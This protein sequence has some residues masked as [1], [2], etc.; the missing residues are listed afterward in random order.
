MHSQNRGAFFFNMYGTEVIK[1]LEEWVPPGVAWKDD[2][3]GLQVGSEDVK[4]KNILVALDLNQKVVDQAIQKNCNFIFTHHPFIFSPIKKLDFQNDPK[5]VIIKELVKNDITLYSAHTNLDFTIGGVSFEL[6]KKLQLRDIKFLLNEKNNQYKL[7]VFVPIEDVEVVSEAIFNAGGGVIG[8]YKKCS[9]QLVGEGT[10]EGSGSSN[11]QK[12]KKQ[13]FET[14]VE[15][16]LEVLVNSWELKS[17]ISA[18]LSVHPYEE[19]AYDVYVLNNKN[20]NYGY[21]AIGKLEKSLKIN[22]FLSH[23]KSMLGTPFLRFTSCASGKIKKVAVCGG[24]GSDLISSAISLEADAYI[25][26][27]IKYHSF[28]DAENKILLIDAGHYETEVQVLASVMKKL[29]KL[30]KNRNIKILKYNGSTNPVKFFN[31]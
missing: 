30:V 21:G 7:V 13:N 6:A 25:T 16:R 2:N 19:P 27:D 15:V 23:V 29:N 26:A 31:N 12:G 4:I 18:M 20:S 14:V 1:Y 17:V 8:E 9:S 22:D 28:Q 24:S 10:F 11:P 5:A 3:V